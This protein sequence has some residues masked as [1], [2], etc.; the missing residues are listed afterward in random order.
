MAV[1]FI[2]KDDRKP[3]TEMQNKFSMN[4]NYGWIYTP[5]N[6]RK[7]LSA[8]EDKQNKVFAVSICSNSLKSHLKCKIDL[9]SYE[10]YQ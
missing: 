1:L 10:E 7:V 5:L 4:G 8:F 6:T 2:K 9:M 3:N